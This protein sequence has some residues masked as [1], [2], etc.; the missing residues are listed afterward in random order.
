[1]FP[2]AGS[3]TSRSMPR[4]PRQPPTA[5]AEPPLRIPKLGSFP[6]TAP[7]PP[8]PPRQNWLRSAK[9]PRRRKVPVDSC[10]HPNHLRWFPRRQDWL[11]SQNPLTAPSLAPQPDPQIGFVPQIC[12]RRLPPAPA[13]LAS[14]CQIT[15]PPPGR[16]RF[17]HHPNHLRQLSH[18]AKI[19]FVPKIRSPRHHAPRNPDPKLGSFPKSAPPP[20]P[21]A[22]NWLR[23]LN[24]PN[25]RPL[26]QTPTSEICYE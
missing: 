21:A 16:R 6:K 1:M 13:K 18:A 7:P 4:L 17:L 12:P 3:Q 14:F 22:A 8:L 24:L 11:R 26:N 9:S 2:A 19:G 5:P 10:I 15:E 23:S 25:R 20:P